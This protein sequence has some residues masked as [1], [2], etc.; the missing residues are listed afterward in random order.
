MKKEVKNLHY[1]NESENDN[2]FHKPVY[3]SVAHAN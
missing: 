3:E 2:Y 1:E